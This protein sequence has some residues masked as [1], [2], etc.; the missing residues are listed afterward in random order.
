MIPVA[1]VTGFLGSGKTTLLR[2]YA[3]LHRDR[4]Y[5]YLVNEFA[6]VDVD[7]PLLESEA[8]DIV[9]VPGGS[10]FCTCLV[11]EFLHVMGDLPARLH[12]DDAPIEG[13][14]IE[15][16]GIANPKV[17]ETMFRETGL[18]ATYR[19]ASI[20]VVVDPGSFPML[21]KVLPNITAQIESAD[22]LLLNKADC[23]DESTLL[24]GEEELRRIRPDAPILRTSHCN[25]DV[26]LFAMRPLRGLVG[27]YASCADTH[28]SVFGVRVERKV[29]IAR[30]M[31][32]LEGLDGLYRAKG[33]LRTAAGP[34]Y[35]DATRT[36]TQTEAA[37][38]YR[39]PFCL[40]LIVRSDA[41]A[42]SQG[43]CDTL[44]ACGFES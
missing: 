34:M 16:S 41:H 23:F 26:D 10:I 37:P 14:I 8:V 32:V 42:S 36:H 39:G 27:S 3:A 33:F 30:L 43:L 15:A 40:A 5:V 13:V 29:D 25:I 38:D 35:L 7:G 11:Q 12:H 4:R 31:A 28:F 2:R 1:L 21:I 44:V 6:S 17:V 18:D 9:S 19:I 22:V 24:H 20:I